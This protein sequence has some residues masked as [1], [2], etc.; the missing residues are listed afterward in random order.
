MPPSW[1]LRRQHPDFA[2]DYQVEIVEGE[3]TGFRFAAQIKGARH[4]GRVKLQRKISTKTLRYLRDAE[5]LPAFIF[6]ID[7]DLGS[8][9]WV[10]AQ[11]YLREKV[12]LARL[13]QRT[14]TV[15]FSD[16]NDLSDLPRFRQFLI[17][18][19]KYVT[20][21]FPGTPLAAISKRKND[22]E[23]L[24]PRMEVK[25]SM[26]EGREQIEI[27]PRESLSIARIIAGEN[28]RHAVAVDSF[29]RHGEPLE[30]PPENIQV[31]SPL[32]EALLAECRGEAMLV[33]P[34]KHPGTLRVEFD[35]S[36]EASSLLHIDGSWRMG[37]ESLT[38][39]GSIPGTPLT[40]ES[41]IVPTDF[42]SRKELLVS[43]GFNWQRWEGRR[44]TALPWFAEIQRLVTQIVDGLPVRISWFLDGNGLCQ[45]ELNDTPDLEAGIQTL[46]WFGRCREICRRFRIDAILPSISQL[47]S[48]ALRE[49]DRIAELIEG[50]ELQFTIPPQPFTINFS[51]KTD[52]PSR[53]PDSSESQTRFDIV[54][55]KVFQ[56]F[57][58]EIVLPNLKQ[59]FENVELINEKIEGRKVSLFWQATDRSILVY[60]W[61]D[62]ED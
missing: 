10:F 58:K 53:K 26:V 55:P 4:R 21:L 46:A 32:L 15:R 11:Q 44:L 34:P 37:T 47:T 18:A 49:T 41:R 23:R 3:P 51:T 1:L 43:F 19:E 6:L 33:Q 9:H 61:L 13:R 12:P 28:T 54:S 60:R 40:V 31:D 42:V 62:A 50:R 29:V 45:A 7:V 27:E 2:V 14:V 52:L 57:G 59:S 35:T 30:L 48:E 39:T 56:F 22:L 20:D 36:Q 25:V 24:D 8:A 38:F 16:E 17:R 5:R